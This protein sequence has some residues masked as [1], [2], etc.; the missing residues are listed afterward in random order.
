M[1]QF[2]DYKI[3]A[4]LAQIL[5][6][7]CFLPTMLTES[8]NLGKIGQLW[9][10]LTHTCEDCGS[11]F[12]G[13]LVSMVP[14]FPLWRHVPTQINL[15]CTPLVHLSFSSDIIRMPL[16]VNINQCRWG[17]KDDEQP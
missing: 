3:C 6:V 15:E 8:K 14:L 4:K 7:C 2:S 11:L 16:V 17:M 12:L 5:K 9:S 1:G 10:N 13:K